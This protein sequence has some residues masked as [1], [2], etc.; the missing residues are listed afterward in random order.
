MVKV[1]PEL[2]LIGRDDLDVGTKWNIREARALR[3]EPRTNVDDR[4]MYIPLNDEDLARCIRAHEM[5]HAKVSPNTRDFQGWVSRKRASERALIIAEESR[6]NYLVKTL[7]YPIEQCMADGRELLDAEMFTKD[8][9]W[10]ALV[11]SAISGVFTAGEKIWIEGVEK[12]NPDY[13]KHLQSVQ[14]F[15]RDYWADYTDH[16]EMIAEILSDDRMSDSTL[17]LNEDIIEG[18]ENALDEDGDPRYCSLNRGFLYTECLA[19]QIDE[20]LAAEEYIKGVDGDHNLM[21]AISNAHDDGLCPVA[22]WDTLRFWPAKPMRSVPGAVA[23]KRTPIATGK[24][25]RRLNRFLTD[26]ERRIFDHV[27]K[28]PGGIVLIDG[29][30]SMDWGIEDI[31]KMVMLAPGCTIAVYSAPDEPT[32]YGT[33]YTAEHTMFILAE[34]GKTLSRDEIR[35][36]RNNLCGGNGCDLPALKWAISKRKNNKQ[37]IVWVTDGYVHGRYTEIVRC[38]ALARRKGVMFA[39]DVIEATTLLKKLRTSR[40]VATNIP[41]KMS[42][43]MSTLLG[44]RDEEKLDSIL[45]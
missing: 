38:A 34:A 33:T 2:N 40:R 42:H 10:K 43:A 25:P 32:N 35:R 27:K 12:H 41:S 19:T 11:G 18:R 36:V 24:N 14:K 15:V 29:S 16:R 22:L 8:E 6:V 26:P 21:D 5:V 23:R 13:A 17:E 30:G 1:A 45:E 39:E 31:E 37:P 4:E 20:I 7:G 9:D 44:T 28:S 3:G